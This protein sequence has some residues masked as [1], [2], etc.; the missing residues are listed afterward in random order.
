MGGGRSGLGMRCIY[1]AEDKECYR[2]HSDNLELVTIL[3]C[4]NAAG[5]IMPP[6]FVLKDGLLPD[7]RDPAFD[8]MGG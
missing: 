7:P 4:A 5:D 2:Q 6:Y 1:A 3:E 8:G